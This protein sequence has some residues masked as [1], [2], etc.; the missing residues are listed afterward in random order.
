MPVRTAPVL[1]WPGD[2]RHDR[3]PAQTSF[4]RIMPFLLHSALRP[5]VLTQL[6]HAAVDRSLRRRKIDGRVGGEEREVMWILD[7]DI[8]DRVMR[9]DTSEKL[10]RLCRVGAAD[11]KM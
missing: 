10:M 4:C 8:M 11:V 1:S 3:A 9:H 7:S 6:A 2:Q 5:T